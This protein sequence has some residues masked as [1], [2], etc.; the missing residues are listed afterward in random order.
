[1][2]RCSSCNL[3]VSS[4]SVD[5]CISFFRKSE[6]F[7]WLCREYCT[8]ALKRATSRRT[9]PPQLWGEKHQSW[10]RRTFITH[11]TFAPILK[12]GGASVR[13]P[14]MQHGHPSH[15]STGSGHRA[16]TC[17]PNPPRPPWRHLTQRRP[18]RCC[19]SEVKHLEY[20]CVSS[21]FYRIS[22]LTANKSDIL[23]GCFCQGHSFFCF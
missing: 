14:A 12:P 9:A 20:K 13:D 3:V 23:Q 2:R 7:T 19:R 6:T 21:Y 10:W 15:W 11:W 16:I 8:P 5:I 22:D 1:M 17:R 4:R 18:C